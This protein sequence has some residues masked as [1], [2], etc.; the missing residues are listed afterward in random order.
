VAVVGALLVG[1]RELAAIDGATEPLEHAGPHGRRNVASG[2]SR[3]P[4][5]VDALR[6]IT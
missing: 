5:V 1:E 2:S 4:L 3:P 6:S